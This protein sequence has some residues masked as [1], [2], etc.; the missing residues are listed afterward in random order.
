MAD[1]K[2][3]VTEEDAVPGDNNQEQTDS[4]SVEKEIGESQELSSEQEEELTE[5]EK[6]SG[7]VAELED[8]LLRA[9]AEFENYKK[10]MARNY[11]NMTRT[12]S[13][14]I[15]H[16]LLEVVDSFERALEHT[17]EKTDLAGFREGTELIFNQMTALLDKH[18]VTPIAAVGEE[19]DPSLHE[20]MMQVPSEEYEEGVVAVEVCKGYRHGQHVLR[21][22]KVGVSSGPPK[23]DKEDN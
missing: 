5:E 16:E 2:D 17:D 1:K 11:E 15:L 13:E 9:A 3:A 18:D 23:D 6:L 19:F 20:A 4:D 12:A 14:R 7:R 22:T 10:R 21:H 8:K